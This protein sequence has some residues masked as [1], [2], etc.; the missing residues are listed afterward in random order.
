ML[1]TLGETGQGALRI[2]KQT[3]NHHQETLEQHQK[4]KSI[5]QTHQNAHKGNWLETKSKTA[6]EGKGN[7]KVSFG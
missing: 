6:P 5:S 1:A 2:I 4:H 7:W 3:I